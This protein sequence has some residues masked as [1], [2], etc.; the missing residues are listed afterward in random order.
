MFSKKKKNELANEPEDDL[1]D[2][3][4]DAD[5]DDEDYEDEWSDEEEKR[6]A[7][8]FGRKFRA[9]WVSGKTLAIYQAYL[10][11]HLKLPFQVT[12]R[13]DFPW[14]ERYVFGHGSNAEYER[15]KKT[16]PSY[17]DTFE[18]LGFEDHP[19]DWSG[20]QARIK[21]ITDKKVFVMGLDWL[22]AIDEKS[23]N[24]QLLEDYSSWFVNH[25]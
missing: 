8:I 22:E 6:I 25:R 11:E 23:P 5:D 20:I 3:I 14:E 4:E 10:T 13:E 12:G 1:D 2:E 21:R 9:P 7:A 18:L 19:N 24:H 16:N 15:M 17:T